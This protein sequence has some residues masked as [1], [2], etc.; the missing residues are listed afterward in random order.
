MLKMSQCFF[1]VFAVLI[2]SGCVG[3]EIPAKNYY[4]L[5]TEFKG[6]NTLR[7]P[8]EIA[9]ALSIPQ[10]L[11]TKKIAYKKETKSVS[12]EQDPKLYYFAKNEWVGNTK[13][14]LEDYFIQIALNKN[15]IL[16]KRSTKNTSNKIHLKVIDLYYSHND[17]SVKFV[18][19]GFFS[20]KED[21]RVYIISKSQKVGEEYGDFRDIP[22]A[23][24]EV[25]EKAL[26]GFLSTMQQNYLE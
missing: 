23:F 1:V 18:A 24:S 3:R 25:L 8:L 2:F 16:L 17:E 5:K 10:K 22:R 20:T 7:K 21:T 14:I 15:N 6:E 19:L 4:E 13:E 11:D 12:S 9:F 26:S